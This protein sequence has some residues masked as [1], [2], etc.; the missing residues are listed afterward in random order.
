[1]SE[2]PI[3]YKCPTPEEF[4]NILNGLFPQLSNDCSPVSM[5]FMKECHSK[6]EYMLSHELCDLF[7]CC[8]SSIQ[9]PNATKVIIFSAIIVLK[10]ALK[11]SSMT[12]IKTV[13]KDWFSPKF[14]EVRRITKYSI[15]QCLGSEYD[16]VRNEAASCVTFLLSIEQDE[17][18]DLIPFLIENLNSNNSYFKSGIVATFKEIFDSNLFFNDKMTIPSCFARLPELVHFLT[19]QISYPGLDKEKYLECAECLY[20]MLVKIPRFFLDDLE[21]SVSLVLNSLGI[22]FPYAE[23]E[24][25]RKFHFI[26]LQIFENYFDFPN[27]FMDRVFDF[28]V[29]GL[30]SNFRATSIDFWNYVYKFEKGVKY[31]YEK[32]HFTK[33]VSKELVRPFLQM[34]LDLIYPSNDNYVPNEFPNWNKYLIQ[35]LSGFVKA[36]IKTKDTSDN[37]V[38]ISCIEFINTCRNQ[39]QQTLFSILGA[40]SALNVICQEGNPK[41]LTITLNLQFPF[42]IESCYSTSKRVQINAL[43]LL[44]KFIRK[45]RH[46]VSK[47]DY[48]LKIFQVVIDL[49]PSQDDLVIKIIM[50]MMIDLCYS[51]SKLSKLNSFEKIMEV[52]QTSLSNEYFFNSEFVGKP[53]KIL[54]KYF[55]SI[56]GSDFESLIK[57]MHSRG[58]N[59]YSMGNDSKLETDYQ[60]NME[61][62]KSSAKSLLNQSLIDLEN[63]FKLII[64]SVKLLQSSI[65]DLII[66]LLLFLKSEAFDYIEKI[67][68][69]MFNIVNFKS[70]YIEEVYLIIGTICNIAPNKIN[71]YITEILKSIDI[72]LKSQSPITIGNSAYLIGLVF[73]TIGVE[74]GE[75][76][77]TSV[78]LLFSLFTDPHV[79][80]QRDYY[81]KVIRAIGLIMEGVGSAFQIDKRDTYAQKL[82]DLILMPINKDDLSQKYEVEQVF[83]SVAYGFTVL[84]K[85]YGNDKR[86]LEVFKFK[87][88]NKICLF[89]KRVYKEN[90]YDKYDKSQMEDYICLINQ[91]IN[92]TQSEF[93]ISLSCS[94]IKSLILDAKEKLP[95][96]ADKLY[97]RIK[98]I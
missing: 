3:P 9:Q 20:L 69:L 16:V 54:S 49:I 77:G 8:A 15:V 65:F 66:S 40:I 82:I 87:K 59:S 27:V 18:G 74:G 76:L 56:V 4:Q 53:Y 39:E 30:S 71:Q 12:D 28:L 11:P 94:E 1:M 62:L 97:R 79:D 64:L 92:T 45:Q 2:N 32:F 63:S 34:L 24:L 46:T 31:N 75:Y 13:R 43:L 80:N 44:N 51:L 17:W 93:N 55:D 68:K 98:N 47:E 91:F 10:R 5:E 88:F 70:D 81:S 90:V 14:S 67:F 6:I 95:D 52:F 89:L 86:F 7:G 19:F 26:M 57:N 72:G 29:K 50:E 21:K 22:A 35:V 48:K 58:Y 83:S 96:E 60:T 73:N 85:N 61:K 36:A 42:I 33:I 37:P 78:D 41:E 38:I 23:I 25:Y 84:Y